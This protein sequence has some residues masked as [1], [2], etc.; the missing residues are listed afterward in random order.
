MLASQNPLTHLLG[1]TT[2][3]GGLSVDGSRGLSETVQ[4]LSEEVG[5]LEKSY[6][7]VG[8]RIRRGQTSTAR[9]T[10]LAGSARSV[11]RQRGSR[12]D[13]FRVFTVDTSS[14]AL[15]AW[16]LRPHGRLANSS[17]CLLRLQFS[18]SLSNFPVFSASNILQ[19]SYPCK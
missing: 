12:K 19:Q 3:G 8:Y 1:T 13:N 6:G 9:V 7:V 16:S 2:T 11:Q 10:S 18:R 15:T 5:G 4:S 17:A 14:I